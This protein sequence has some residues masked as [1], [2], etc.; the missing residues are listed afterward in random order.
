MLMV[1]GL[2]L[3]LLIYVGFGEAKRTY[4]QMHYEKLVAQGQIVQNAM[5]KVLRPGLPLKQYVGF[6]TLADSILASD[7]SITAIIAYDLDDNPVFFEAKVL[8]SEMTFVAPEHRK[9]LIHKHGHM[10]VDDYRDR[11]R[12]RRVMRT[13][14][15]LD[16]VELV[17][18]DTDD[19]GDAEVRLY[20]FRESPS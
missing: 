1:A 17:A 16:D 10:H 14:D 3:F 6:S 11:N 12:G 20:R 18:V 19:G 2:S 15:A 5:E 7:E 4:S 9:D 8:I 13:L